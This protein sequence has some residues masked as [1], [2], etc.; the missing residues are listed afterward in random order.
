MT[1]GNWEQNI[2]HAEAVARNL[3]QRGFS[4]FCPHLTGRMT[5]HET[6]S[7]ADWI[8]NDLPWVQAS[9]AV[10]RLPGPSAGADAECKHARRWGVPV[11]ESIA[12]LL[13]W[14]AGRGGTT[15]DLRPAGAT[16]SMRSDWADRMVEFIR[17]NP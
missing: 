2:L 15:I 12:D 6:I 8:E 3:I 14:A 7:H 9:D 13:E 10:L 4:V 1:Q 17:S 16:Q 11:F 5:D